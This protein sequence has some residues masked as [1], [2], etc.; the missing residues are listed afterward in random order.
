MQ[1]LSLLDAEM[2]LAFGHALALELRVDG[3]GFVYIYIYI[4]YLSIYLSFFLSFY[5]SIAIYTLML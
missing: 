2:G 4:V 1:G 5:S 3:G